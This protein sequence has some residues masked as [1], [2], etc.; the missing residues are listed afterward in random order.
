MLEME[1]CGDAGRGGGAAGVTEV[2]ETF[3][4][5]AGRPKSDANGLRREVAGIDVEVLEA[6]AV[7]LAPGRAG[8]GG[9]IDDTMCLAGTGRVAA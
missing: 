3:E 4:G 6:A 2:G 5:V 1:G 8:S 7:G 9:G